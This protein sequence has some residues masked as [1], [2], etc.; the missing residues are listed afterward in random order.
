MMKHVSPVFKWIIYGVLGLAALYVV[1]RLGLAFLKHMAN[2]STWARQ[3]LA[4]LQALWQK[5]FGWWER[6]A[7]GVDEA[8]ETAERVVLRPFASYRNPFLDGRAEQLSPEQVVRYSF[9]ALQ[10]W[11]QEAGMGRGL[12]ETPLEFVERIGQ[13]SPALETAVQRLGGLYVRIAYARGG[14]PAAALE[15]LREFWGQLTDVAERTLSAGA[16]AGLR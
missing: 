16:T 15:P 4:A 3:L 1:L 13:E 7:K 5:L 12:G 8:E 11:A 9:E 6:A 10:A 2:F 14:L